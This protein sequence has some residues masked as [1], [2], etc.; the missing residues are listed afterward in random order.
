MVFKYVRFEIMKNL[1]VIMMFLSAIAGCSDK[2]NRNRLIQT[3]EGLKFE[4]LSGDKFILTQACT[5]QIDYLGSHDGMNDELSVVVKK[6][7]PCFPQF[8]AVINKREPL[9]TLNT[10]NK[11]NFALTNK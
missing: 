9:K 6:D 5:D 1:F 2:N 4:F 3:K 8:N 7:K 10:K 11:I